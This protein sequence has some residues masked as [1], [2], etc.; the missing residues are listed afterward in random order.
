MN[1]LLLLSAAALFCLFFLLIL[2][3]CPHASTPQAST[4]KGEAHEGES[5][6]EEASEAEYDFTIKREMLTMPDGV[7]LA[8]SYWMP[9]AGGKF[10]VFFEM[11]GYRKDDLCYL[12]WD[13]P[14]G[15]YFA[16]RGYVVARVDVR[17]TGDSEGTL[18]EAEYSEHEISDAVEVINQLSK[19]EWSN[20][21]VGMYGLSWGAFNSFMTAARKPAALKAILIAHVADD[22][23]YQDVHFID[24]VMHTDVWEAMIDTYN[25]LP[26]PENL[27]IGAEY[28]KERF[29][30]EPWHFIWK[31]KLSDG[32]FWRRESNRFKPGHKIRLAVGNAQFPMAWPTP[33][34][35]S[36][37]LHPG[38]DTWVDLPVVTKNTLT[39]SCD[40]PKPEKEEWPPDASYDEQDEGKK[41]HID[42]NSETGEAIYSCGID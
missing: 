23:Y 1:R 18:P 39:G 35:G 11:N 7:K 29:D 38:A 10:P 33:Y 22:L 19:K 21:R 24:G 9:R 28:F 6:G 20:G 31:E 25:A 42:Y 15:A 26:D 36:T 2:T 32:Q 12:S 40:L 3:G 27:E 4:A 5:S 16:R 14:V 8:V 30:R 17:G 13:Y 41:T 34:K 37:T